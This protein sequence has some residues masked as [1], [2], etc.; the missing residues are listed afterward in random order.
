MLSAHDVARELRQ[1]LPDPGDVKIHKLAYYC[2]RWHL[3]RT[4]E[5]MFPEAIEAAGADHCEPCAGRSS[6]PRSVRTPT[7]GRTWR[8]TPR[9]ARCSSWSA[10]TS[11]HW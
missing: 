3:A 11:T 9:Y 8:R 6:R 10:A 5:P 7:A 4:G 2:Q 1:R